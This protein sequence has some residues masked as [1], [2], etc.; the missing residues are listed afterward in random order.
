MDVFILSRANRESPKAVVQLCLF[1][2]EGQMCSSMRTLLRNAPVLQNDS[3][4]GFITNHQARELT[5]NT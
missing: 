4:S 1:G 5:E 3:G 2:E